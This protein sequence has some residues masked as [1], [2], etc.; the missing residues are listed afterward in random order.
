VRRRPTVT[1][2]QLHAVFLDGVPSGTMPSS[3]PSTPRRL[4]HANGTV[5]TQRELHGAVVD[6]AVECLEVVPNLVLPAVARKS[7]RR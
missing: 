7:P 4:R 5:S 1:V 3:R 6:G 2:D